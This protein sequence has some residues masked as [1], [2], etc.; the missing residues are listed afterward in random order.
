MESGPCIGPWGF[1]ESPKEAMA[2]GEAFMLSTGVTSLSKLREMDAEEL[3]LGHHG[4]LINLS[5]HDNFLYAAGELPIDRLRAGKLNVDG[6]DGSM[7]VGCNTV[8]SMTMPPWVFM[9]GKSLPSTSTEFERKAKELF[10]WGHGGEVADFY[11]GMY[12]NA[13]EAYQQVSADICVVCPTRT[14]VEE[15]AEHIPVYQYLYAGGTADGRASHASELCALFV[16]DATHGQTCADIMMQDVTPDIEPVLQGYWGS[17]AAGG[18][19]E[20]DVA[21]GEAGAGDFMRIGAET[22]MEGGGVGSGACEFW[23]TLK[24]EGLSEQRLKVACTLA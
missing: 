4:D 21:W 2:A 22:K 11:L 17:F 24:D 19:P 6:G 16:D 1:V 15:L 8:D 14:V 12:D 9:M 13:T 5:S 7:I 10:G 20:G 18:K 3:M 23:Q